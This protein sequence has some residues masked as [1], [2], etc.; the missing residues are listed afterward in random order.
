MTDI[1]FYF[2]IINQTIGNF[3]NVFD[4]NGNKYKKENDKMPKKVVD[5]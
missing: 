4:S 5:L 1:V 3:L 2:C